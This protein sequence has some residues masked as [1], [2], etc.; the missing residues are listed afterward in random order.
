MNDLIEELIYYEF[1]NFKYRSLVANRGGTD[2]VL[3][4]R[5]NIENMNI[6]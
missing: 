5:S 4:L 2:I 3:C 1:G 6:I